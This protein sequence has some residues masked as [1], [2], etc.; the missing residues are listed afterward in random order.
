VIG[1]A[2][3]APVGPIGMLFIRKTLELGVAGM[4][5]VGLGAAMADIVFCIIVGGGLTTVSLFLNDYSLYIKLIGGLIL[6]YL[7]FRECI[8]IERVS[9]GVVSRRKVILTLV[10]LTFVLTLSNP[11]AIFSFIGV[12]S[13]VGLV[14]STLWD[15]VWMVLG[16][17]LGSLSWWGI[18]GIITFSSKRFMSQNALRMIK[19]VSGIVLISFGLWAIGTVIWHKGAL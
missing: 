6:L 14:G 8:K 3:A 13:A 12:F 17:F 18:L 10:P 15:M 4:V 1:I 7:G 5:G 9:A 11:V 16:I 19:I 2:I